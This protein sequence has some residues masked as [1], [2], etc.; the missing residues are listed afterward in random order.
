LSLFISIVFF[1]FYVILYV[2]TR[3]YSGKLNICLRIGFLLSLTF[4]FLITVNFFYLHW[5]ILHIFLSTVFVISNI[6]LF[7]GFLKQYR[8][9]N[10]EIKRERFS[11]I[12]LKDVTKFYS[13]ISEERDIKSFFKTLTLES[14]KLIRRARKATVVFKK[15]NNTLGFCF[16]YGYNMGELGKL[17]LSKKEFMLSNG[18]KVVHSIAKMDKE[19]LDSKAYEVLEKNGILSVRSTL[20]IP[21]IVDGESYANLNLDILDEEDFDKRDKEIGQLISTM[22]SSIISTRIHVRSVSND[23]AFSREYVENADEGM[24]MRRLSGEIVFVNDNT[25]RILSAKREDLLNKNINDVITPFIKRINDEVFFGMDRVSDKQI[26]EWR[27]GNNHKKYISVVHWTARLGNT[28]Y[29]FYILTDLT[30]MFRLKWLFHM[31]SEAE[32]VFSE[33]K[34]LAAISNEFLNIFMKYL[35]IDGGGFYIYDNSQ[36]K[37]ISSIGCEALP[38]RISISKDGKDIFSRTIRFKR[39]T[40]MDKASIK[41]DEQ[42]LQG[43]RGSIVCLPLLKGN[44]IEG[45][46]VLF[47][48]DIVSSEDLDT[49]ESLAKEISYRFG[50]LTANLRLKDT[51]EELVEDVKDASRIF[52]ILIPEIAPRMGWFRVNSRFFPFDIPQGDYHKVFAIDEENLGIAMIDSGGEGVKGAVIAIFIDKWIESNLV[53]NISIFYEPLKFI[54]EINA[55][56][57]RELSNNVSKKLKICFALLKTSEFNLTVA[58]KG[59]NWEY[60]TITND[61][62]TLVPLK[63][64]VLHR[65]RINSKEVFLFHTDGISEHSEI[66]NLIDLASSIESESLFSGITTVAEDQ[67]LKRLKDDLTLVFIDQTPPY[68]MRWE[69]KVLYANIFD[70]RLYIVANFAR[71]FLDEIKKKQPSLSM[72][73][74]YPVMIEMI[75]NAIE[76]GNLRLN[77]QKGSREYAELYTKRLND[78]RYSQRQ[79]Q[80]RAELEKNSV[81]YTIRDE[82]EGF[83]WHDFVTRVPTPEELWG[84]QGRGIYIIR[85]MSDKV[86]YND[87]GNELTATISNE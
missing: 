73:K 55:S 14:M 44:S 57:E 32:R 21:I 70:N 67:I 9:F 54:E 52:K 45:I 37:L 10:E 84:I 38:S 11:K 68:E 42:Y 41:V 48:N 85:E 66:N 53:D 51:H 82:G 5:Y 74:H 86:E 49:M 56:I 25:L 26:F 79:V 83:N 64:K 35:A 20:I 12:E 63:S 24:I 6:L 77:I 62:V 15:E 76:H 59:E 47:Y 34:N 1:I 72:S 28:F 8:E 29:V 78:P 75:T 60:V 40:Y 80:V 18:V 39:A 87:E 2:I 3:T 58:A 22:A 69:D 61:K 23:L 27:K 36:L 71:N 4:L 19:L 30:K 81:I 7:V 65:S 17:E 13:T 33:E 31:F 46:L 50:I 43:R 16:A